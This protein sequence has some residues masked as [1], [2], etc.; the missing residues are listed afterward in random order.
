MSRRL[1]FAPAG[2]VALILS[3]CVS[4]PGFPGACSPGSQAQSGTP[5]VQSASAGYSLTFPQVVNGLLGGVKYQTNI[6]LINNSAASAR[7]TVYFFRQDGGTMSVS[8]NRG[9]SA[10]FAV[11]LAPGASCRI[12]TDGRGDAVVGWVEVIS[13]VPLSGSGSFVVYDAAGKFQTEVGVGD[14]ARA[15]SL[16]LHVSSTADEFTGYAICNPSA[17]TPASLTYELRDLGGRLISSRSGVPLSPRGQRAEFVNQTFPSIAGTAFNGVLLVRSPDLDISVTTLRSRGV[18]LTSLPS[19]PLVSDTSKA[20]ELLFSRIADGQFGTLRYKTSFVL[21]NNSSRNATSTLDLV[22]DKGSALSLTIGGSRKSSFTVNV[23]AGGAVELVSDGSSS[24]AATGWATVKSDIPLA[25]GAMFTSTD[26]A[27]GTFVSQVGVPDS[28]PTTKAS[29]FGQVRGDIDTAFAVNNL[30]DTAQTVT[31]RLVRHESSGG[32]G[33]VLSEKTLAMAAKTHTAVFLSGYFGE[34]F[35]VLRRNYEGWFEIEG[36]SGKRLNALTLRTRGPSLTSLPVAP[37]NAAIDKYSPQ[38]VVTASTTAES[39]SAT[40]SASAK[41]ATLSDGTTVSMPWLSGT[42]SIS[43]SLQKQNNTLATGSAQIATAGSM[44]VVQVT[45]INHDPSASFDW[46]QYIPTFTIP[47]REVGSIGTGSVQILR[48]GSSG[49]KSYLPATRDAGGNLRFKDPWFPDDIYDGPASA[50]E[51]GQEQRASIPAQIQYSIATVQA[52]LNYGRS[53]LLIRMVPD[54]SATLKRKPMTDLGQTQQEIERKKPVQNIFVLVHGHNET[55]KGGNEPTEAPTPWL[56]NYKRDVWTPFYTAYLSSQQSRACA[57]VF[58]E[59]VYPSYRAIFGDL[60]SALADALAQ[61]LGPQLS[62]NMKFNLFVVA[63]SMGGLVS[64]AAAQNFDSKLSED[65]RRLV[66]WGSPHLGSPLYTLRMALTDDHYGATTWLKYFVR[67][68]LRK[69]FENGVLITPGVLDLRWVVPGD[70]GPALNLSSLFRN[71][72]GDP[73]YDLNRSP[74]LF[75]S[76]LVNLNRAEKYAE[77]YTFLYGLTSKGLTDFTGET[78][79]D[80][81][82]LSALSSDIG[83]G[84]TLNRWLTVFPKE[85]YEGAVRGDS[86]GAVPIMSMLG[87]GMIFPNPAKYPVGDIDHEAYFDNAGNAATTAHATFDAIDFKNKICDCPTIELTKPVAGQAYNEN[88]IVIVEGKLVWPGDDKPGYRIRDITVESADKNRLDL[89]P[90]RVFEDGYFKT[91]FRAGDLGVGGPRVVGLKVVLVFKDDT[92]LVKDVEVP[93]NLALAIAKL[94]RTTNHI[95]S[96]NSFEGPIFGLSGAYWKG[97]SFVLEMKW[98]DP[99]DGFKPPR[100][101][102]LVIEGTLAPD[103]KSLAAYHYR[104]FRHVDFTYQ[105]SGQ[106]EWRVYEEELQEWTGKDLALTSDPVKIIA[107]TAI[108]DF[109][110]RPTAFTWTTS[111]LTASAKNWKPGDIKT[112]NPSPSFVP[113]RIEASF[114]K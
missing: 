78:K 59:F 16:L 47:A 7:G 107:G 22:S 36:E 37:L 14:S 27:R 111:A 66:T 83:K 54:A 89:P 19:V 41:S 72:S 112:F 76:N 94:T 18:N 101:W 39:K 114:Y 67:R 43:L 64:R 17:T 13:N 84:S 74:N 75:N 28:P 90:P 32:P 23:P 80:W 26:A 45:S 53:P 10:S 93:L 49:T 68:E 92:E 98:Y 63:H 110:G 82:K 99:L 35:E 77:K 103:G 109:K 21:L 91:E 97:L 95:Y 62:N 60:D 57:T 3:L 61:E 15:R 9:Q 106:T 56:Y 86:D 11:T 40:L 42:T 20:G 30:A 25:G 5:S 108:A 96:G 46:E 81:D 55:E 58:F 104:Q 4:S 65:L 1:F 48:A 73:A 29:I 34:V 2:A 52:S 102:D 100:A 113:D 70:G 51:S 71:T 44:R 38:P 50:P 6:F 69:I 33:T 24:P 105:D 8:T 87:G 31:L 79:E 85:A 88:D 12:E